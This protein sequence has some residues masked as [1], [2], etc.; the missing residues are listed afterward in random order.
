M[1]L[2]KVVAWNS[3]MEFMVFKLP[4]KRATFLLCWAYVSAQPLK[5]KRTAPVRG[6]VKLLEVPVKIGVRGI[7]RNASCYEVPFQSA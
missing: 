4:P 7:I 3:R 1:L 2:S 5:S 6:E